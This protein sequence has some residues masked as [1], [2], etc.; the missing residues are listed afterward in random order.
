MS[1]TLSVK[2]HE[3]LWTADWNFIFSWKE[4]LSW[5]YD[6]NYNRR[7]M[8]CSSII[9]RTFSSCSF[10]NKGNQAAQNQLTEVWEERATTFKM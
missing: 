5:M 2:Q 3:T 1:Q 10:S 4:I 7:G 6:K 8:C 9:Q